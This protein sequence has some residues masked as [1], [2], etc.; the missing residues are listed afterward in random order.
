MKSAA[1]VRNNQQHDPETWVDQ[2][3]DYLYRYAI[4]RVQDPSVAEDLIQETLLGALRSRD[5]F[6]GRSSEKTWLTGI[7]KH[8]ILDHYRKKAK[9]QTEDDIESRMKNLDEIFDEKGRWR[10]KPANWTADPLTLYEQKEFLVIFYRCL[11]EMSER[12]KRVFVLREVDG[13]KTDEICK[14]LNISATNCWV[15]LY[16]AR[17]NLRR[18]LEISW[19]TQTV[20]EE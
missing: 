6:E 4:F 2:Y 14:V 5:K 15:M 16:R 1:P 11:S 17:M 8:K 18:C 3:G 13:L 12:L 9:E 10:I 19:F 20:S 7:L